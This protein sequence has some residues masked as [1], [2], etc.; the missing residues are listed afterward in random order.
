[1]PTPERDRPDPDALLAQLQQEEAQ[2][3]RGKL[4][5]YFGAS[6]GVGKTYAMLARGEATGDNFY[7]ASVAIFFGNFFDAFDGRVA[8]AAAW[9]ETAEPTTTEDGAMQILGLAWAGRPQQWDDRKRSMSLATLAPLARA[10]NAI[11]F[12][13]LQWGEAAG[14]ADP[15]GMK[16]IR[17]GD[18]IRRTA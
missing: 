3:K 4:R 12:H 1:V 14:Q 15:P 16:L 18:R 13:S 2:A 9:L 10:S 11:S 6:A 17:Y 7:R 5:I 8:R